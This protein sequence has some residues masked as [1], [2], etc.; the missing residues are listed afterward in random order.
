MTK[1][2]NNS[3]SPNVVYFITLLYIRLYDIEIHRQFIR[4]VVFVIRSRTLTVSNVPHPVAL[5][6]SIIPNLAYWSTKVPAFS[7][8]IIDMYWIST[9]YE[10]IGYEAIGD[11]PSGEARPLPDIVCD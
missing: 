7:C 6:I 5:C 2:P 3:N 1:K 8:G 10:A 9:E 4:G 11:Q